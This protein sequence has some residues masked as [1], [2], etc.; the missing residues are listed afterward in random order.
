M[1]IESPEVP[2]VPELT[3]QLVQKVRDLLADEYERCIRDYGPSWG[4][5]DYFLD[6]VERLR[7]GELITHWKPDFEGE[8][9]DFAFETVTGGSI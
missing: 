1:T 8:Y 5:R 9:V 3:P 4:A 2:N 7:K 6:A